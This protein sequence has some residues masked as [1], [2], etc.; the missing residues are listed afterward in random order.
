MD[1]LSDIE[2]NALKVMLYI[3]NPPCCTKIIMFGTLFGSLVDHLDTS[4][5][6]K[7]SEKYRRAQA[8]WCVQVNLPQEIGSGFVSA[9]R[10][11]SS[12]ATHTQDERIVGAHPAQLSSSR[13]ADRSA[14]WSVPLLH[15]CNVNGAYGRLLD[16][17]SWLKSRL[18][19][20]TG[21]YL[22][23]G[24]SDCDQGPIQPVSVDRALALIC[25][26]LLFTASINIFL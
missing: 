24:R 23:E 16:S 14:S 5:E 20:D 25:W 18:I 26:G 15:F 22:K 3:K 10:S 6:K 12:I 4:T 9:V 7:M 2:I 17:I 1:P 19:I 21:A 8:F 11:S 13:T